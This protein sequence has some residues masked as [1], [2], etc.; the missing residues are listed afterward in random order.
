[1]DRSTSACYFS[2]SYSALDSLKFSGYHAVMVAFDMILL[3][4]GPS[5]SYNLMELDS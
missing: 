5:S 2:F 1:M 4:L 3:P